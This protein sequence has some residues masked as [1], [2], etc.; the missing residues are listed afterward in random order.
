MLI[1]VS[2]LK[3]LSDVPMRGCSRPPDGRP[4]VDAPAL[5]AGQPDPRPEADSNRTKAGSMSIQAAR[6]C[7]HIHDGPHDGETLMM[8]WA[9]I[10]VPMFGW[11][12]DRLV[13]S[14]YRLN[15]RWCG[16]DDAH[17]QFVEQGE[18]GLSA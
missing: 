3:I 7:A 13:E 1:A 16:Q 6:V 18:E 11:D 2:G 4:V 12:G 15:G 5:Q 9:R 8:P 14:L 10:E 17:Y